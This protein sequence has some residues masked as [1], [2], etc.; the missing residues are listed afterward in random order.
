MEGFSFSMANHDPAGWRDAFLRWLKVACIHR[1]GKDDYGGVGAL[2]R[3]FCQWS[4]DS[5]QVP[6]N[7]ATF[8]S[9]LLENGWRIDK[10]NMVPG[11]VLREDLQEG[12]TL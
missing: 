12:R 7:R 11:L 1:E 10:Y 4:I 2:H 8:D 6:C 5:E 9:L 3:D